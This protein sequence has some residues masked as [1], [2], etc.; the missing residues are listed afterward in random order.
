MWIL[1]LKCYVPVSVMRSQQSQLTPVLIAAKVEWRTEKKVVV[2]T[3]AWCT[4]WYIMCSTR[5]PRLFRER[6]VQRARKPRKI[7]TSE[8][9][10]AVNMLCVNRT[11]KSRKHTSGV[12]NWG[13]RWHIIQRG[14]RRV[15]CTDQVNWQ[16]TRV[17]LSSVACKVI[18]KPVNKGCIT[19]FILRNYRLR[20]MQQSS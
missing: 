5:E 8:V 1:S 12:V 7:L 2:S 9:V 14:K 10:Q 17:K 6:G 19:L 11:H 3:A 18:V 13:S 16:R 20:K 15:K 4:S